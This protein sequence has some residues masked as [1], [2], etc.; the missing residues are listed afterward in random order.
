[1]GDSGSL[2]L[3]FVIS[4]L[5]IKSLDYLPT[6]SIL[7]IAALPIFD[8][9]IVMTRRKLRGRSM[10]SADRCHLHHIIRH[11]FMEDTQ[12]TVL[13]FGVLQAIYSITGL[14]QDKVMDEGYLMIQFILNIVLLYLFLG[15]M[16]KR[17]KREC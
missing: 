5:A 13:F 15:A 17:Q 2:T 11:F 3:G 8:T 6:V 7:F 14:Q 12:K 16:I 1:M 9:L 4:V 10:F